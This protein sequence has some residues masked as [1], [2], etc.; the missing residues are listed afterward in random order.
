MDDL[1]ESLIVVAILEL[2]A[3]I[4]EVV[5]V[6]LSLGSHVQKVEVLS[7]SL[8]VEGASLNQSYS[9]SLRVSSLRNVSKSRAAP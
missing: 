9:T 7:S 5:E 4:S 8:L 1:N 3:N 6:E 2:L